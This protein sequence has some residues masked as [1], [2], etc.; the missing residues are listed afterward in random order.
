MNFPS[1]IFSQQIDH[2]LGWAVLHSIWQITLIALLAGA[3]LFAARHRTAAFRYGVANAALLAVVMATTGTFAWQLQSPKPQ[4]HEAKRAWQILHNEDSKTLETKAADLKNEPMPPP[5]TPPQPIE[6]KRLEDYFYEHQP[7]VV[8]LWLLGLAVG[9]F[10]LLGHFSYAQVLR[11]RMNFHVDPYWAEVLER[12]RERAR[13]A[14]HI[15]LLE[16]ALVRSPLTVGWLRPAILFPIGIVN[17]LSE[18][19][20][21]AIL[22]HELAH[23]ARHDYLFNLL[24]SLVETLFY[25]HPAVWWLSAQVRNERE[26]ACD[27]LAIGW[28]GNRLG[29]AKALVAMQEMAHFPQTQSLVAFAGTH[30]GQLLQRV[31]RLFSPPQLKVYIME[32]WIATLLVACSIV[33]L[34]VAQRTQTLPQNTPENTPTEAATGSPNTGFWHAEFFNDSVCLN[35]R[36]GTR[37]NYW[38]MGECYEFEKSAAPDGDFNLDIKR[39]AGIIT[40]TGKIEGDEG[41]GKFKFVPDENYRAELAR[42]GIQPENDN[43]LMHL[44]WANFPLDYVASMRQAGFQDLDE[45]KLTQLAIFKIDVAESQKLV[46]LSKKLGAGKVSAEKLV[47]LK[48]ANVTPAD[49]Q[50]YVQAGLADLDLEA[51][52]GLSIQNV[53]PAFVERMNKL[54]FGKLDAEQILSAKIHG[55]T[56]EFVAEVRGL[57]VGNPTLEEI[58]AMKIHGLGAAEIRKMQSMGFGKL[59]LD[60]MMTM[61]IHGVDEA[62][63][64]QARAMGFGKTVDELVGMKIHGITPEFVQQ[65]KTWGLGEMDLDDLMSVRIHRITPEFVEQFR[66]LGFKNLSLEDLLSARIHDVTPKFIEE[67]GQRGYKFPKLREYADLKVQMEAFGRRSE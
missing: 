28:L 52:T 20:V 31:Q 1:V 42:Q 41:Y 59:S 57:D 51:V 9:L 27:D 29:Y 64:S 45:D 56:P 37:G 55:I 22:A 34:A 60:E 17:R 33:A 13:F 62:F 18:Q 32:K 61:K 30:R 10:R 4:W 3:V 50:G 49:V 23:I 19:E 44:F 35:L 46:D 48:I 43:L 66:D 25:Y 58:M 39:P 47:E 67:A 21:E 11:S 14:K 6:S 5:P 40:L 54:G 2:A 16:S 7:L 65:A 63:V 38:T 36:S 24:Q 15:D 8:M 53:E 26:S 12:L